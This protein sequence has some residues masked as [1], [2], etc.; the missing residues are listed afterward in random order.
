MES[1]LD[2]TDRTEVTQTNDSPISTNTPSDPISLSLNPSTDEPPKEPSASQ[3]ILGTPLNQLTLTGQPVTISTP[4]GGSLACYRGIANRNIKIGD[5]LT[6]WPSGE[7]PPIAGLCPIINPNNSATPIIRYQINFA[8]G[9]QPYILHI[10]DYPDLSV[11]Y[12]PLQLGYPSADEKIHPDGHKIP[13]EGLMLLHPCDN[14]PTFI[15]YKFPVT[16]G[17]ETRIAD[18][19]NITFTMGA[20]TFTGE[21]TEITTEGAW[22]IININSPLEARSTTPPIKRLYFLKN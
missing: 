3:E 7:T 20:H 4:S 15:K 12:Y 19:T 10:I 2:D 5:P 6:L 21:I 16:N 8:K 17:N 18:K 11:T 13:S 1:S 14:K 9:E 22:L